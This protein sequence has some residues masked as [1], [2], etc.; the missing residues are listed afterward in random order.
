VCGREAA[1]LGL[2]SMERKV[3]DSHWT[4]PQSSTSA[5]HI[6][7]TNG[8]QPEFTG[9]VLLHRMCAGFV[10]QVDGATSSSERYSS[11]ESRCLM[12]RATFSLRPTI[13]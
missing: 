2:G 11:L 4:A 12:K 5:M 6:C 1:S 9:H 8:M 13:L 10:E 3:V 7:F